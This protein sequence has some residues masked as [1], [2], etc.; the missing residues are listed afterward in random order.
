MASREGGGRDIG[1]RSLGCALI[2]CAW[3]AAHLLRRM[4]LA[5]PTGRIGAIALLLSAALFLCASIGAALVGTGAR[6]FDPIDVASR[7]RSPS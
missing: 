2:G 3:V 4:A 5:H 7:W 6:I 1:L